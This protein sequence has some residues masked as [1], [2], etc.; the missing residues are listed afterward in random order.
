[1]ITDASLRPNY[2]VLVSYFSKQS[3]AADLA[4]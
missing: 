4:K 1:V 3:A 2:K